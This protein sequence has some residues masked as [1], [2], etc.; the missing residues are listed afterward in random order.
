MTPSSAEKLRVRL[1]A[2]GLSDA[3]ISAAWPDWWTDD[4]ESSLSAQTELRFGVARRLGLDP[5]SLLDDAGEP[6][7]MWLDET[8]FKH[9]TSEGNLERAGI[10][11]FGRAVASSL[12]NAL[13]S[14]AGTFMDV[15]AGTARQ[16]ILATDRPF[17]DLLD[18]LSLCWSVGVPV[19][20]MRVFPWPQKRMAAMAVR[21]GDRSAILLGKDAMYPAPI[22][23]YIAH[24]LGHISLGHLDADRAIVDLEVETPAS[25][26]DDVEEQA[27]DE[28]ALELLTGDPRPTV[29][30]A[31]SDIRPSS[32]ELARVALQS[33]ADLRIEPGTLAL[34]FG[35]STKE[36]AVANAA[37]QRIYQS[38]RPVWQEINRVALTQLSLVDASSDSAAFLGAVLGGIRP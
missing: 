35:Y 38:P 16:T 22:A 1:T 6:R 28:F 19:I 21:V 14:P 24:E 13:P 18:L 25:H 37:L 31:D 12:V 27:A 30:P 36:W 9:L 8:R 10:S 33:A 20:H 3:A 5:R 11:S 15:S 17:V 7:F 4:A 2:L 32:A 26:D 23:F 34:C 29:L